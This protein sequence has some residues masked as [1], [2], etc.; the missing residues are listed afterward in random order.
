MMTN[1]DTRLMDGGEIASLQD[2]GRMADNGQ[3]TDKSG[4]N[5]AWKKVTFGAASGILVGAGAI[6]ASQAFAADSKDGAGHAQ[7][8][9]VK[10]A[11][12]GDD[13]SF[14]D[15]FDAARAQV[16]PGGVFRWNGG[17]YNTYKEDEW[18]ALSDDE[19]ADFAQ[20]VHPEVRADEIVAER[21][22]EAQPQVVVIR[23]QVA[24]AEPRQASAQTESGVQGDNN[25]AGNHVAENQTQVDNNN[26]EVHVVGQGYVQGHQAVAVDLTGNGEADVAIVDANDNNLLDAPDVV[27][28]REGHTATLGQIAQ[29][30]EAQGQD[31]G[32]GNASDDTEPGNASDDTDPNTDPNLQQATYEN[33]D[34]SPDMPDDMDDASVD[35]TLV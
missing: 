16:G 34:L 30:Q 2:H 17:L 31:D 6:Y 12:V 24:V 9:D 25:A 21:M 35:G 33:P 20:A 18:N 22:S 8:E 7:T 19:K 29:A 11:K 10:V 15:A 13:L 1:E 5:G 32:Y 27:V 23:E 14:Q 28:D 4:N 3:T 26:N